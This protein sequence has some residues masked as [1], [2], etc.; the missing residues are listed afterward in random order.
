MK[1]IQ[2]K[3]KLKGYSEFFSYP[4]QSELS[5][6]WDIVKPKKIFIKKFNKETK[7]ITKKKL[8][9]YNNITLDK[10]PPKIWRKIKPYSIYNNIFKDDFYK[11]KV[12]PTKD[13]NDIITLYRMIHK[14]ILDKEKIKELYESLKNKGFNGWILIKAK[15]ILEN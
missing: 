9:Y 15:K 7:K 2:G 10:L 13:D 8:I 12:K 14:I 4:T 6:G 1:E 11:F 3:F 5:E